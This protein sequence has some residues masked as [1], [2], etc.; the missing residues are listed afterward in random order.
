MP[1]VVCPSCQ[2]EDDLA[3]RR[4]DDRITIVC[5]RCGTSWDRDT[6]PTCRLCGST[7]LEPVRTSTLEEAGRGEQ[8]T[9][10]GIRLS[11][12]CWSCSGADVTS[13]SPVP[14]PNPPP[15]THRDLRELRRRG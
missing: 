10:S 6:E 1:Q 3:G 11:Y 5:G 9:P 4:E 15:G 8:R 14:G 12:Y 7:D 13:G 2:E